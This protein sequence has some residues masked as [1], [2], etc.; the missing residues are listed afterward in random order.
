[1]KKAVFSIFVSI[2]LALPAAVASADQI[3]DSWERD[4]NRSFTHS[5]SGLVA[6]RE[7]SYTDFSIALDNSQVAMSY[8]RDL[9]RASSTHDGPNV[10]LARESSYADFFESDPVKASYIRD[11][12]RS[13]N[14][15]EMGIE[16]KRVCSY[17]GWV[18]GKSHG[19]EC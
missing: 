11:I 1:M 8:L 14:T 15:V 3:T 12:A 6:E 9:V 7:A 5:A 4:L 17:K 18:D 19:E 2:G 13:F 16:A 10:Q